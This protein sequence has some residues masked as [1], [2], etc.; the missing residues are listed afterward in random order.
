MRKRPKD[1]EAILGFPEPKTRTELRRFLG[2]VEWV[3]RFSMNLAKTEGPLVDAGKM[4]EDIR[5]ENTVRRAQGRKMRD[6]WHLSLSPEAR[7]SFEATKAAIA[8]MILLSEFSSDDATWATYVALDAGGG[9]LGAVLLQRRRA[10]PPDWR[11]IACHSRRMTPAELNYIPTEQELL[12]IY[13]AVKHWEEYLEGRVVTI[14]SDHEPLE[15]MNR[16]V[17]QHSRGRLT[18]WFLFLQA[19]RL[20]VEHVPGSKNEFPD[21]LSRMF[22]ESSVTDPDA[23]LAPTLRVLAKRD[24]GGPTPEELAEHKLLD[25]VAAQR[26][27]PEV[28]AIRHWIAKGELPEAWR[29]ASSDTVKRLQHTLAK[30]SSKFVEWEDGVLYVRGD[31]ERTRLVVPVKLRR[32]LVRLAHDAPTGGHRGAEKTYERLRLL[33]WWPGMKA[34]IEAFVKSCPDCERTKR[35]WPHVGDLQPLDVTK[36]FEFMH[37]DLIGPLPTTLSGNRFIL[38]A[39]DRATK[40]TVLMALPN[41]E[42]R[43][44]ARAIVRLI[45]WHGSAPVVIQTDQ[46]TEFVNAV[47]RDLT[48]LLGITHVKGAAYHPQTNGQAERMNLQIEQMLAIFGDV[49][50]RTWDMDLDFVMYAL[51]A[52]PSEV[53]GETPHFLAWG[54][55]AVEPMDLLFGVDPDPV[56]SQEH[57]LDR[58]KKARELA[59]R[60]HEEAKARMK[61]RADEGKEPHSLEVGDKV[62]VKEMRVPKGVSPKLRAKAANVEYQV[63]ELTGGGG[64]HA[65]VEA[66][67]N[68]LDQRKVHVERLKKVVLEPPGLFG[69][70]AEPAAEPEEDEYEV[71]RILGHRQSRSGRGKEYY[72][73]WKGFGAAE[74]KWVHEDKVDAEEAIAAYERAASNARD[75]LADPAVLTYAEAAKK[76][77]GSGTVRRNPARSSR[78]GR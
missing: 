45:C 46:G 7:A 42:A 5:Q 77:L 40:R 19:F 59:A 38:N 41:K 29:H 6:D 25:V 62:W 65:R 44:V 33:Y 10:G 60:R 21:A 76:P 22:M 74:D 14:F 24:G 73:R 37:F 63:A 51:N 70:T 12:A 13:F 53:T 1:V 64:K 17:T 18:R 56:M 67:A 58:L 55:R 32:M 26:A 47:V 35:P 71:E 66:V 11:I 15:Y 16:Q 61:Q 27:C 78:K 3:R 9:A 50:Q 68:P 49:E 36:V 4:P 48:H 52:T 39:V 43:T 57:W 75:R 31:S 28:V 34:D 54:R 69:E 20:K 23:R 30:E 8:E 72:I 2:A